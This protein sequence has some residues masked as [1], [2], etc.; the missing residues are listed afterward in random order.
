[1]TT[2]EATHSVYDQWDPDEL[3]DLWLVETQVVKPSHP[4]QGASSIKN[5]MCVQNKPE[6]TREW[7]QT[8]IYCMESSRQEKSMWFKLFALHMKRGAAHWYK[9][10]D[11][12]ERHEWP[13]FT[14]AFQRYYC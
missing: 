9:Q 3:K 10:L 5:F 13:L 14:R 1:M 12:K 7:F 8:F 6:Q 4:S 11:K 2:T